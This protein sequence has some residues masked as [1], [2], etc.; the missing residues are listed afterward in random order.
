[1]L[2]CREMCG[3]MRDIN[4]G[5]IAMSLKYNKKNIPLARM[6]RKNATPQENH[7]WYGFL[8]KYEVR[9]QRQKAIDDF[10]ADFYCHKAKLIIEIDGSQ[11]HT[12]QGMKKDEFRT[13]ILEGYDLRVIRFT[14]QQIDTCFA[15]VCHYID[16]VVK[17]SLREG[18][19]PR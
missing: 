17:A 5:K 10:I 3:I 6:L 1:M 13:E 2:F 15:D 4:V 11:H 14:N 18:G 8:S 12:E 16:G 19:G 9:F 7:L